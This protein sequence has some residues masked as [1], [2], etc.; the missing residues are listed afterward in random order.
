MHDDPLTARDTPTAPPDPA[1]AALAPGPAA[2]AAPADA[3]RTAAMPRADW[4]RLRALP[5][6]IPL[7]EWPRHGVIPLVVRRGESRHPV[8]FVEAGQR[9]Y[10][11]KETS[12]RSALHESAVIVE[13]RQRRCRTLEPVGTVIVRGAP[14]AAGE[15]AGQ[16]AYTSGDVGYCVTR[17]AERVLP[18]SL[19]YRYPFTD[20]N[21]R[22]LW[23]A[24]AELLL[25][26]HQSGV[27]WG[28]PSLAN[29][30]MDLGGHRLTAV[31]ADAET[32]E[33]V[34]GPL[35]ESRRRQ[36]LDTFVELLEWQAEDIRL[37]RG[38]PEAYR[39]V[40][41]GDADYFLARYEG[42]RAERAHP[43]H[44]AGDLFA[45]IA[46]LR[47]RI[48]RLNALGY[49]VL[50][51]GAQ[52]KRAGRAGA[53]SATA[54]AAGASDLRSATLRSEWY[55]RELRALLG[56]RVPR[57]YAAR[58][59]E[60]LLVHKWLLSERAHKDIGLAAAARDWVARYHE[61]ALAFL[62]AYLP[63]ADPRTRYAEYLNILDHTWRMSRR[64]ARPIPVEEG[65]VDYALTHTPAA[66]FEQP[67]DEEPAE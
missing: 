44:G 2:A 56:T 67:Q 5:W 23:S 4:A 24:V 22:L 16:P 62:A 55:A 13:L 42:L 43:A 9:R 12:P 46:D 40:T 18:Q 57:A 37:A 31:M 10:A 54:P 59:Y 39:L 50:H 25:D 11:L 41:Q 20:A 65:A 49:G 34:V 53:E 48:T 30:L 3:V 15:I 1:A 51:L 38:L 27:Y 45:R 19:L 26:L 7:E 28:D 66:P 35:S 32:A 52:A 21:K 63:D 61:P 47:G 17:L 6:G 36:D 33:L 14:I 60:H 29:I 64:E 58:V 8:L